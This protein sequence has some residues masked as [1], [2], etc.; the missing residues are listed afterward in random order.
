[1]IQGPDILA[2]MYYP[3]PCMIVTNHCFYSFTAPKL[4]G[5]GFSFS[6]RSRQALAILLWVVTII[7]GG[8]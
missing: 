1:M 5:I 6:E 2:L 8:G 3:P 4:G 7:Q